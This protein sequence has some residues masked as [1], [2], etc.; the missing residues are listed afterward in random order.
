[1][2]L[3]EIKKIFG[4]VGSKIA[5]FLYAATVVLACWLAATGVMNTEV[6]WVNEHGESEYGIRAIQKL[7]DAR[8]E[9]EGWLNEETLNQVA[10]ENQRI[11][12]TPQYRSNDVQQSD[13]AYGWKQ[14]FA[15][16]RDLISDSYSNGFREYD[17]YTADRIS[18]IDEDTFYA[19]RIQLLKEWLYDETDTAY[20][21]YSEPEKQYIIGIYENLRTP[22]YFDYYE[23]W[24]QLLA[25]AGYITGLGILILGFL[26]S[27]IFSNEFR[28]KADSI[29][30]SSLYGRNKA[31]SAKIKA[32]FLLVTVLYWSAML[33]YSLFTLCYLGFE[34]ANCVIQWELWK[35]IYNLN[36][37]QAWVLTL[38]CGYI[39]NLF[40]AFLTMWI[41]SK[42]KST[43]FAVT[44][45]FV[46]TFVPPF[47]E[48]ISDWLD[49]ILMLTPNK[50]MEFYQSLRTFDIM[51]IFGKVYRVLDLCI[52][53][54][55]VLTFVMIPVI[56]R[57]FRR[58]QV[59]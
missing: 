47:L 22:F 12:A 23:G 32:G 41:S 25:N 42:T 55:A 26:L 5:L 4:S 39:G 19:N 33:V 16:I 2:T 29:Y 10:Q 15:P 59:A 48:G 11:N 52:P 57:E 51:T 46:L 49:K 14:G 43:V 40:L 24:Y 18:V 35:T 27:G 37:W 13:I 9:W 3:Y 1:M 53:L 58:K 21:K 56:Y 17:Y 45:P 8:N 36:M 6:K 50:L 28:W 34:G 30:F 38:I 20:H 7:R 54:Y 44:V 31:T